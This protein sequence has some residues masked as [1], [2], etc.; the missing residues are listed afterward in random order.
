M[1]SRRVRKMKRRCRLGYARSKRV[2]TMRGNKVH[3]GKW[4]RLKHENGTLEK[5]RGSQRMCGATRGGR[6]ERLTAVDGVAVAVAAV[7]GVGAKVSRATILARAKTHGPRR[8]PGQTWMA[9]SGERRTLSRMQTRPSP[10]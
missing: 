7:G 9:K 8:P 2:S 10:T 4:K 1:L 5:M 6:K 3:G